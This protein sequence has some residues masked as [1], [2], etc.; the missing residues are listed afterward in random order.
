MKKKNTVKDT[1]VTCYAN[2][3]GVLLL[4]YP[5]SLSDSGFAYGGF[6]LTS[7]CIALPRATV[8]T[9]SVP[10]ER[11]HRKWVQP[12]TRGPLPPYRAFLP[13]PQKHCLMRLD[14]R[15]C[16]CQPADLTKTTSHVNI[17][18]YIIIDMDYMYVYNCMSLQKS[19]CFCNYVQPHVSH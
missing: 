4:Q 17:V 9:D 6:G 2:H 13:C 3:R 7:F 16:L 8:Q 18:L 1:T 19:N 12:S 14:S 11:K 10:P 15:L 5:D